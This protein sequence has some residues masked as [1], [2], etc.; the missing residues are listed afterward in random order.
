MEI[1][2]QTIELLWAEIWGANIEAVSAFFEK[3]R[4]KRLGS[5]D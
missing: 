4:G 3:L 2:F 1:S 5:N